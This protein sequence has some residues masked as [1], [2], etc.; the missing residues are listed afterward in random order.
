[1]SQFYVSLSEDEMARDIA[2]LLNAHNKLTV[3]HSADTIKRGYVTYFTEVSLRRVVGCVGLAHEATG[4]RIK[5]LCVHPAFRGHGIAKRLVQMAIDNS[6]HTMIFMTIRDDN[7]EC[8]A[9]AKSMGFVE[10]KK[11]WRVDHYVVLVGRNKHAE[12][13]VR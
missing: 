7:A 12:I 6:Q 9:L 8:L 13:C 10:W 3:T 2:A 11:T 1:M 5:H 4:S